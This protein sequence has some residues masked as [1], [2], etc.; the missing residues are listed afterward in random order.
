VFTP[1][2]NSRHCFVCGLENPYGLKL[3]FFETSPGEVNAECTIPENYQ[4]YPGVV[5][6]GIVAAMLDEAA[7]RVHMGDDPPR[8]MYTARIEIRYRKNVPVGL[9]LRLIG[10]AGS[11]KRRTATATSAIYGPDGSLLAEADVLLVNVPEE[12][13]Q[14]VD[15]AA[16]GWKV[17]PKEGMSD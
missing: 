15:L 10:K 2:P 16:L 11:S 5:H 3:R 14:D 8:F 6:G 9:P 17:Y 13:I 4:G 12:A 1:Q 7:G